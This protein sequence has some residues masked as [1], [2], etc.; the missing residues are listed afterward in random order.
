[1][2]IEPTSITGKENQ[3]VLAQPL[4][5]LSQFYAAFNGSDLPKMAENWAQTEEI[6]MDNPLGGIKRGWEEI[7]AVY[8]TIFTGPAQVTV[9]FHDYTVHESHDIFYAEGRERG[10]F[11]SGETVVPLKIRTTRIF[12]RLDGS[13]R[14]VHHHGSI[15]EPELLARYQKAVKAAQE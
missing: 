14:Q 10:E 5:A 15:D 9:E 12:R 4:R 1:M 11:R 3:E 8:K 2:R 13:W 7:K 6:S